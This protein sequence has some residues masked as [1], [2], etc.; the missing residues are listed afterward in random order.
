MPIVGKLAKM[1]RKQYIETYIAFAPKFNFELNEDGTRANCNYFENGREVPKPETISIAELE[2]I[3]ISLK[4][5]GA[6][7]VHISG[8]GDIH[9]DYSLTIYATHAKMLSTPEEIKELKIRSM[10]NMIDEMQNE[11]TGC[12]LRKTYVQGRLEVF[13]KSLLLLKK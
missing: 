12:D 11:I 1:E 13:N 2:S 5:Q 10:Q 3:L 8:G 7:R 4:E 6:N 9:D